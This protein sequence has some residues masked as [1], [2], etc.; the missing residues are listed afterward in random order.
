MCIRDRVYANPETGLDATLALN[1]LGDRLR[2]IGRDITPDIFDRG[3]NQLD[4]SISKKFGN[5]GLRFSAQ[6]LLNDNFLISSTNNRLDGSGDGLDYT[7]SDFTTG[8]TFGLGV[9]YTIR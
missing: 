7:Y 4:F 6:N 3:R 9:S 1:S 8:V 2:I 5:L